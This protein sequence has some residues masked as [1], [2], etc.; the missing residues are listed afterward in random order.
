MA[1]SPFPSFSVVGKQPNLASPIHGGNF[2]IVHR[3]TI[4]HQICMRSSAGLLQRTA[5]HFA[6][7]FRD[8]YEFMHMRPGMGRF[9]IF[10]KPFLALQCTTEK[11]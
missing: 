7:L 11:R 2:N 6:R 1:N 8:I 4:F 5:D 9:L 10:A 3:S